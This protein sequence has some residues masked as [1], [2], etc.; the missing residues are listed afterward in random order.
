[1]TSERQRALIERLLSEAED[2][3]VAGQWDLV[4]RHAQSV[5]AL[6]ASNPDGLALK[7]AAER[8]GAD[9]PKQESLRAEG[10][11][12]ADGV[13]AAFG[14]AELHPEAEDIT[15][16]T[17]YAGSP[18]DADDV[19]DALE[20]E[21][22]EKELEL[23][24]LR[25]E[26]DQFQKQYMRIVGAKYAELDGLRAEI[27]AAEAARNPSDASVQEE[28][29]RARAQAEESERARDGFDRN[30]PEPT[31]FNPSNELKQLYKSIARK[32]H[33]D[34]ATNE[35]DRAHRT[36]VMIEVNKAYQ[37]ED[38]GA[39][40]RILLDWDTV[41]AA[42]ERDAR[43]TS[44][45]VT[46]HQKVQDLRRRLHAI[47]LELA[48]LR[49]SELSLLTQK[50][51]ESELQGTDLLADLAAVVDRDIE[52]VRRHLAEYAQ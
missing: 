8:L 48:A 16:L 29:S 19:L 37:A 44:A 38:E 34:L 41:G 12:P 11:G 42:L 4:A 52:E 24:T 50:V 25:A 35:N 36:M 3:V 18:N 23:E 27:A 13:V 33:P 21:L 49:S 45:D 9:A 1:M 7:A 26:L 40:R 10:Q 47:E 31:R 32:I 15:S 43:R 28:A 20:V 17:P 30:A 22:I 39:L 6:E 5:L 14:N 2:A 46:A 51:H